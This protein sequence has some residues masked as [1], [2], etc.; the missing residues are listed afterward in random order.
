[1]SPILVEGFTKG[2]DLCIQFFLVFRSVRE[3]NIKNNASITKNEMVTFAWF[4][5]FSEMPHGFYCYVM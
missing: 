1:M 2:K 5:L 4:I 3:I